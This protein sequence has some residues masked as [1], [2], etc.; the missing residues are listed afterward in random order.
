MTDICR[1]F[2]WKRPKLYIAELSNSLEEAGRSRV[3]PEFHKDTAWRYAAMLDESKNLE[4]RRLGVVV[5]T[6]K[7]ANGDQRGQIDT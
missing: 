4:I 5:E 6:Y 1:Y 3:E 2:R 7:K